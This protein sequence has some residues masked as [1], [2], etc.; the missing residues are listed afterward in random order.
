MSVVYFCKSVST[1]V[2][3][4]EHLFTIWIP[5][6]IRHRLLAAQAIQTAI[7]VSLLLA[8]WWLQTF[9]FSKIA[10]NFPPN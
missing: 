10:S 5:D 7:T 2:L 4:N 9:L 3:A 6:H 1:L 8:S